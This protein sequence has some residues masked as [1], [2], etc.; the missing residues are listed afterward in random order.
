MH[1]PDR[2]EQSQVAAVRTVNSAGPELRRREIPHQKNQPAEVVAVGM[3]HGDVVHVHDLVSPEKWRHDSF[4]R[5]E[6]AAEGT[7]AIDQ[8]HASAGKSHHRRIALSYCQK[9]HAQIGI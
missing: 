9:T 2:V 8:H 5:I 6:G 4:A 3:A 1:V 7:T